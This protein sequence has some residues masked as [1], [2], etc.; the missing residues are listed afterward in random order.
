MT[1]QRSGDQ[2]CSPWYISDVLCFQEYPQ[3]FRIRVSLVFG[4]FFGQNSD[5]GTMLSKGRLQ[6]KWLKFVKFTENK[7]IGMGCGMLGGVSDDTFAST[8]VSNFKIIIV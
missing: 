1:S 4:F 8:Q 2:S 3:K 7:V 6:Y 5:C